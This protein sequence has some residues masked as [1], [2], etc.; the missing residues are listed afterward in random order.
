VEQR[1]TVADCGVAA[2]DGAR[3]YLVSH[4]V[5]KFKNSAAAN[6]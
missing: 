2:W 3:L 6:D 5:A 4:L 1:L